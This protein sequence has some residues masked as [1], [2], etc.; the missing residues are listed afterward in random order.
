MYIAD[1]KTLYEVT[2]DVFTGA[3][4]PVEYP[5][6]QEVASASGIPSARLSQN[7]VNVGNK[8]VC[9]YT[10]TPNG[11]VCFTPATGQ[12]ELHPCTAA[13]T[14][15]AITGGAGAVYV[16]GG[17]DANSKLTDVVDVISFAV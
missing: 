5:L 12:F 3:R 10:A 2:K 1:A 8:M 7:G 11:L 14:A 13:H 9:F 16:A 15:G 6:P 4:R 17:V